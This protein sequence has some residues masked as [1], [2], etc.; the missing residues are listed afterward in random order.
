MR[1]TSSY[2]I[3]LGGGDTIVS[4]T[5]VVAVFGPNDWAAY[6]GPTSYSNKEIRAMGIKLDEVIAK[7]LFK[8]MAD[9]N[10]SY[11]K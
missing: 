7:S 3:V 1:Q 5:K 6:S 2:H 10:R 9:T 8:I 11:R 4:G